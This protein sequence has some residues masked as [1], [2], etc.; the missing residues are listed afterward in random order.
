MASPRGRLKS[1]IIDN[2]SP[3]IHIKCPTIGIQYNR[4]ASIEIIKPAIP[5]G[6]ELLLLFWLIIIGCA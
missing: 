2:I 1:P 4:Y 5:I 3:K 6:L